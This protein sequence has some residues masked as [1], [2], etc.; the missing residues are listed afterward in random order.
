[1]TGSKTATLTLRIDPGCKDALRIAADTEHR[2]LANMVEILIRTYC[3]Q[4]GI[5]IPSSN[6]ARKR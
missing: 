5:E 6:Q 4:K 1:M 3:E 2:S